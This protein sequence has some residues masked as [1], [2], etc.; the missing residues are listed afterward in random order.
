MI[1]VRNFTA[2]YP[3]PYRAFGNLTSVRSKDSLSDTTCVAP[4]MSVERELHASIADGTG[5]TTQTALALI[6]AG[7]PNLRSINPF[8]TTNVTGSWPTSTT[9]TDRV[10]IT[11]APSPTLVAK[12]ANCLPTL[13]STSSPTLGLARP[14]RPLVW[15]PLSRVKSAHQPRGQSTA[16]ACLG[17]S[18]WT[19]TLTKT[20]PSNMEV[21][22]K[23]PKL[24][25]STF[26]CG[27]E[28]C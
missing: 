20:S 9:A 28:T 4:G 5:S 21:K 6:N 15:P 2:A 1:Q 17:N 11:T 8:T 19:R 25:T 16:A 13:A 27:L 12:S 7:L 23:R 3:R 26:T 22:G 10:K 24:P 18:I 14:T